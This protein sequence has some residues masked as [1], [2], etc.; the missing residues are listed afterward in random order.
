MERVELLG[1]DA[2]RRAVA[3]R[4][5]VFCDLDGDGRDGFRCRVVSLRGRLFVADAAYLGSLWPVE[6]VV[7]AFTSRFYYSTLN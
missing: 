4:R 7:C 3:E 6:R 1:L 2:V 5:R